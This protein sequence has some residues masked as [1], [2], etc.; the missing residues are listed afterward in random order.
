MLML[1]LLPVTILLMLTDHMLMLSMLFRGCCV[2]VVFVFSPH[3]LGCCRYFSPAEAR[4]VHMFQLSLHPHRVL[5]HLH[6]AVGRRDVRLGLWHR[7]LLH[8]IS[9]RGGG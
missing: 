2:M 5:I 7:A 6:N 9:V 8:N 4:S 3:H 1:L